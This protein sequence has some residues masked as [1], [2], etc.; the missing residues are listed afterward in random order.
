MK[1]RKASIT[2]SI[3]LDITIALIGI[4]ILTS[5]F[6]TKTLTA[7]DNVGQ[8][9]QCGTGFFE[10]ECTTKEECDDRGWEAQPPG[11]GCEDEERNRCCIDPDEILT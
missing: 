4:F 11:I 9:E 1:N 8:Y 6:V 2:G 3:F 7:R 5:I 10:G